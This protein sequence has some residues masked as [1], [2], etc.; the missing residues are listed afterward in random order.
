LVVAAHP[1]DEILGCGGTVARHVAEGDS[2][3][4]LIMTDGVSSRLITKQLDK[5]NRTKALK[6]AAKILGV[7]NFVQFNL[8]DNQMDTVPLLE[9]V[10]TI[11]PIIQKERPDIVYTHHAGDLN[12]D[13]RKTL[14]AVLTACRP[15]PSLSVRQIYGF[16]ILSSTD[17]SAP[18]TNQFSPNLFV[19]ISNYLKTKLKALKAYKKEMK[20]APHS[21]SYQHVEI[22]AR[23]RGN[24]I[25][26]YA[27]EAFMIIRD[28]R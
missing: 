8:P 5:I 18:Q 6:S 23:H 11:E 9:I 15:Q 12:V 14:A 17:W 27:A 24:S 1:D 25:G 10:K 28:L 16:E 26:F 2:V 3:K 4:L 19:D 20:P 21:R 22:L 13:H 7:Q